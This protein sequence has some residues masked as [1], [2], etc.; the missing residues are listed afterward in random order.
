MSDR[1]DTER[2]LALTRALAEAVCRDDLAQAMDLLEERRVML[3]DLAKRHAGD[4]GAR[5]R[6]APALAETRR[7][8]AELLSTLTAGLARTGEQLARLGQRRQS[9]SRS[10]MTVDRKA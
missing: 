7:I 3:E 2:L 8:D 6:L 9:D 5:A 10:T 1:A 4:P